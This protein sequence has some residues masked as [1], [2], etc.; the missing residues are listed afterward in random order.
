MLGFRYRMDVVP[1]EPERVR[2]SYGLCLA[3]D[4]GPLIVGPDPPG[5][6]SDFKA[7]AARL[8]KT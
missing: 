1:L 3:P 8:L 2:G 7:Y 4:D 5:A 6:M